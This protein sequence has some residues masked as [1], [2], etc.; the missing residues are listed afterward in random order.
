MASTRITQAD[1]LIEV[2]RRPQRHD[3]AMRLTSAAYHGT[4]TGD[5]LA[6]MPGARLPGAA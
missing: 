6:A 3:T 4:A 1:L 5:V 2:T